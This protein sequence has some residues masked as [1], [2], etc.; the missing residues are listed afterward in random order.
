MKGRQWRAFGSSSRIASPSSLGNGCGPNL[1][2]WTRT[3]ETE[4]HQSHLVP[5][6]WDESYWVLLSATSATI[7][8]LVP[9]SDSSAKVP[10]TDCGPV[11]RHHFFNAKSVSVAATNKCSGPCSPGYIHGGSFWASVAN[12]G[13]IGSGTRLR[14]GATVWTTP[15]LKDSGLSGIMIKTPIPLILLWY[16]LLGNR[17][18]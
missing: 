13:C 17:V 5:P 16:I 12:L 9:K 6:K 3:G 1:Y 7:T 15:R 10:S 4:S 11:H 2:D 14:E 18:I 8:I